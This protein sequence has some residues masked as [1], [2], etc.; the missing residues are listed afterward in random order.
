MATQAA[1]APYVAGSVVGPNPGTSGYTVLA[2]FSLA[3]T[4]GAASIRIELREKSA[5]GKVLAV[6]A[7]AAGASQ[8]SWLPR[9]KCEGQ[10]YCN[11]ASGTGT[12]EGA[13]YFL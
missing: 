11:V 5:T 6:I 9:V 4:G 2:G 13:I 1:A 8:T 12:A 10:I 7:L 3:E